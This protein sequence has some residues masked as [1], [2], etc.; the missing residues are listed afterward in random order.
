MGLLLEGRLCVV[1]GDGPEQ[2]ERVH[3]LLDTGARLRVVSARPAPGIDELAA[4]G[5]IELRRRDPGT[6]D[7]DD[8][9]LAVQV[10][11][12]AQLA[13]TLSAEAQRR[14]L[15]FCAL[16]QPRYNGFSHL[17]RVQSGRSAWPS[18]RRGAP[19]RWRVGCVRS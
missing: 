18:R 9:W 13:A 10:E 12:N 2:L 16:D 11:E 6:A 15:F 7:L 5:Q 8:A 17:A 19:R 14:R 3:M 4:S 1:L